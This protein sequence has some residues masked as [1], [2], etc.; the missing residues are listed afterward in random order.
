MSISVYRRFELL[1]EARDYTDKDGLNSI[2][3]EVTDSIKHACY[4]KIMIDL[5]GEK[6]KR[7]T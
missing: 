1:A 4:T 3:Y 7:A 6:D 2:Q 5:H